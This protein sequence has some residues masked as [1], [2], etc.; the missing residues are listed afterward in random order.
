[1]LKK[2][3]TLLPLSVGTKFNSAIFCLSFNPVANHIHWGHIH[4]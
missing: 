2:D 3:L 4:Y 1:L